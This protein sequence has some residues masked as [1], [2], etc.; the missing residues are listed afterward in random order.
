MAY[1]IVK[2]DGTPLATVNDG[3]TNS[4][5]TT[6]TLVGKNFAGYGTFLNENLVKLLEHFASATTPNNPVVGQ[7]WYQTSTKILQVYNGNAWKSISGAQSLADEPTYKVAGDLWFDSVNQQLKVW[8]G[9]GWVVI[10][11]SFT[12]T[13]GTSGAVADTIIDS[14]QFSH[15]VV[16]FFVQNQ[17]IAVLSKDA[18]FQPQTTIPGFPAIK[19]GLNLAVGTSP[20]LVF[21]EN[22]NNSAYLGGLGAT[23]YLTKDNALLTSK[24]AIR[25]NDG[26][27]LQDATGTVTNFQLNI[28]NNNIQLLGLVRGNGL[29]IQTK[30]DN[31]GGALQT[32]F[33]VDKLTGLITVLNDPTDPSGV[34]TK[35]YIDN[36]DNTTRSYLQSNVASIN[37]NIQVLSGN[38]NGFGTGVYP[39]GTYGNVR[40]LQDDLGYHRGGAGSAADNYYFNIVTSGSFATNM[41]ALWSNVIS[42]Q[43][44]VLTKGGGG[45][46]SASSM[47]A[48]VLSLQGRASSLESASL[49][50]DGT[51]TVLGT[52]APAS[53]ST[54]TYDLGSSAARFRTLFVDTVNTYSNPLDSASL[55]AGSIINLKT[56]NGTNSSRS[57]YDPFQIIANPVTIT[58]NIKFNDNVDG[59][60]TSNVALG[61]DG[62]MRVQGT[63][64]VQG[65]ITTTVNEA[66]NIGT[67]GSLRYNNIYAK[68]INCDTVNTASGVTSSAAASFGALTT[69][70]DIKPSADLTYNL[71]GI[72]PS[73]A[74]WSSI[75]VR[76]LVSDTG[77]SIGTGGITF[78][79][80]GSTAD[81]G[82]STKKFRDLY[83][84]YFVGDKVSLGSG[85]ITTSD[86]SMTVGT[87]A[88]QFNAMYATTFYGKAT[89]AQYADLAERFEADAYYLPGT[90]VRLGGE[91]EITKEMD[92]ASDNVFGVISTD[93]AYLMN[94]DETV[95]A[96]MNPAVALAGRVP[97]M[98][99]GTCAKGDRLVSAGNGFA[100]AAKPGEATAFNVIG[101]AL[102]DKTSLY[103]GLINCVVKAI[104]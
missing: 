41:I 89:Q 6:L 99:N 63:L 9:A 82:D 47:F 51:L 84:R 31:A 66:Y 57:K 28:N 17:L 1:N 22:A 35:N 10:G 39:G 38:V 27:E 69:S 78:G 71:G 81:I 34:A 83:A 101:R 55:P 44:N 19:P 62:P 36:R 67:S 53:A 70:G 96:N 3:Q 7:V 90:V 76:N 103:E 42:I 59:T 72:S 56:I 73:N 52:L 40:A 30:P 15:V 104:V 95:D 60:P 79:G 48:N 50:R 11:P 20:A 23:S 8:S 100:R 4:T 75:Y 49:R 21:Y 80:T 92:D 77:V 88:S 58:G 102:E 61:V 46:D 25:N 87:N 45:G 97:V 94:S 54:E 37:S 93:P 33:A 13:T 98:V 68:I 26:I 2:S 16:K 14:S 85:G 86:T 5:A 18:T 32:V 29:T 91:K 74:R 43:S 12:S 24:L 65:G 64:T